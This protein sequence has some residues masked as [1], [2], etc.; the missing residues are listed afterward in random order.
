[1]KKILIMSMVIAALVCVLSLSVG[2][3]KYDYN[4]SATLSDGTVLPIY[5]E[6]NNPLIWWVSGADENGQKQYSSVPN[7]R[8]EPNENNDPYVKIDLTT[9]QWAQITQI[10]IFIYDEANGEY[11]V[12][13]EKTLDVMVMN[14]RGVNV[15]YLGKNLDI[16]DVE[17]LYFFEGLKDISN[18]F[19]GKTNLRLIDMSGCESLVYGFASNERNFFNCTNLHTVRLPVGPEY[20]MVSPAFH[21]LRFGNSGLVKMV[22]PANIT[23]LGTDNFSGS[24]SLAS[25]YVLGNTTDLGQRN[26]VGCTSLVNLY[27]LGDAPEQSMQSFY[28]NFVEC[29]EKATNKTHDLR[30]V[31]KYFFFVTTDREYL[32]AVKETIGAIAVVPYGEYKSNPD[33]YADGRYVI[34]GTNICETY[35]GEHKLDMASSNSCVAPCTVCNW[36]I[37]LENPQ[38][39]LVTQVIFDNYLVDGTKRTR[40]ENDG[41]AYEI[42]DTFPTI[43]V[44]LGYSVSEGGQGGIT[45]GFMIN[46]DVLARYKTE[47]GSSLKYGLFAVAKS[48]IQDNEIFDKEGNAKEGVVA[49]EMSKQPNAA[50]NIKVTGFTTAEQ[51]NTPLVLGAYVDNGIEISY[52]QAGEPEEGEKYHSITLSDID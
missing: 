47:T 34:S 17:Y 40:C 7:N 49:V 45:L 13:N 14:L 23:A 3:V 43:F 2:A 9:G 18:Y 38:H 25:F 19:S 41:C 32:E 31:G 50:F 44:C 26:F 10:N 33:K 16:T 48:K 5:D 27:F 52:I 36:S 12:Y 51:K 22:I 39:T 6:N 8:T 42:R 29:Y 30:S 11:V 21:N 20:S 37:A 4:E 46:R 15:P 28:D 35:Y 24:Q 1:M